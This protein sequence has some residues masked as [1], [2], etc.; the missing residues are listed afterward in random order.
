MRISFDETKTAS[1]L[2]SSMRLD[3]LCNS[4]VMCHSTNRDRKNLW[5]GGHW[6]NNIFCI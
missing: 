6:E 5:G 3:C 4:V 2:P 1:G